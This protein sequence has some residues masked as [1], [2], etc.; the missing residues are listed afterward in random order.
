[1][2]RITCE[3]TFR[4]EKKIY[5]AQFVGHRSKTLNGFTEASWNVDT[6]FESRLLNL[7]AAQDVTAPCSTCIWRLT[8][9]L[10]QQRECG[11][12]RVSRMVTAKPAEASKLVHLSWC[13]VFFAMALVEVL[14]PMRQYLS[15]IFTC[16]WTQ[17]EAWICTHDWAHSRFE[18]AQKQEKCSGDTDP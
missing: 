1:M 6:G 11:Q 15:P 7:R 2:G 3:L 12:R 13:L 17:Y 5:I 8:L 4:G 10:E 16:L 14:C 18:E 9:Q